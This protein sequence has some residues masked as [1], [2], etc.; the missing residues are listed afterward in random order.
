MS[1]AI[2]ICP[3]VLDDAMPPTARQ[4]TSSP[5]SN[6]PRSRPE[7]KGNKEKQRRGSNRGNPPCHGYLAAHAMVAGRR[8]RGYPY[9]GR[10]K[11]K[12]LRL[13]G[14][15]NQQTRAGHRDR[16]SVDVVI[17]AK[18]DATPQNPRPI[19]LC[20]RTAAIAPLPGRASS[21]LVLSPMAP[22]PLPSLLR[23]GRS[24]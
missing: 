9:Q 2:R 13:L 5:V 6:A 10:K 8:G 23:W 17:G 15:P 3:S 24:R 21:V 22:S 14:A 18:H 4:P 20:P 19:L 1:T 12:R 11:K 16:N 7:T